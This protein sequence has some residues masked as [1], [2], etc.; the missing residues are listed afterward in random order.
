MFYC[1][2]LPLL[3]IISIRYTRWWNSYSSRLVCNC[4]WGLRKQTTTYKL[5]IGCNLFHLHNT[6]NNACAS[7]SRRNVTARF[8]FRFSPAIVHV[9]DFGFKLFFLIRMFETSVLL[10][11][12]SSL[13]L[14]E[15]ELDELLELFLC[16]LCLLLRLESP[17]KV[18]GLPS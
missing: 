2:N 5:T 7:C 3:H 8:A 14:L 15:L 11:V 10:I 6:Y 16:F 18:A 9:F 4:Q 13:L 12:R 17:L 1:W